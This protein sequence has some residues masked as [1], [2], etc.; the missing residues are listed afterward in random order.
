MDIDYNTH[1]LNTNNLNNQEFS[2]LDNPTKKETPS[3]AC[4]ICF[5]SDSD[6]AD[7]LISPCRCR[8]SMSH[9][10][11]KCLKQC[12]NTK[13]NIKSGD[14]FI[15]YIWKN[16]ECEICLSEYPKYI[17]YKNITYDLVDIE[18]NYQQYILFDYALYDDTKKKSF[19]KGIIVVKLKN[20]EEITV[21]RTQSNT[22]KLKDIS[23][24]RMHCSIINKDGNIYVMDK[25]SKFGTL[26]YLNKPFLL[27]NNFGNQI[28]GKINQNL[29]NFH[30]KNLPFNNYINLISGKNFLSFKLYNNWSILKHFFSHTLCCKC[31]A[32]SDDEMIINIE[33]L[34]DV[35][36]LNKIKNNSLNVNHEHDQNLNDSY[37]DYILN[38]DTI[39]IW[40]DE[41][42]SFI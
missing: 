9:I 13:I 25:G 11:Y 21:G 8:G 3:Y 36:E 12:I 5:R 1:N 19:R 27:T 2:F 14:D 34:N 20:G 16:I 7:P 35:D 28:D 37:N 38:L 31:K 22:I 40:S 6:I 23:V 15:C 4:R 39:I 17:K 26:I 33:E 18:N 24:S 32:A 42:N 30:Y 41:C 29:M 10:H